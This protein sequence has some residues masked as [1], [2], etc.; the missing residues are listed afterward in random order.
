MAVQPIETSDNEDEADLEGRKFSIHHGI[1]ANCNFRV[2]GGE[3]LIDMST[4]GKYGALRDQV[5]TTGIPS[6]RLLAA[7]RGALRGL[8]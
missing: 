4:L 8:T 1:D 2:H 5:N 7:G 6:T 3:P